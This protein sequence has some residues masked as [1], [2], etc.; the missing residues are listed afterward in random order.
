MESAIGFFVGGEGTA[1]A[2]YL[3][4]AFQVVLERLGEIIII[5]E[6][7]SGVVGGIDVDHLHPVGVALSEDLEDFEI[8]AFDVEVV[9]VVFVDTFVLCGNEGTGAGLAGKAAGFPFPRRC[10]KRET[11]SAS[12]TAS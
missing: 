5:D 10:S 2:I 1:F 3:A 4:G 7:V 12:P 9:G 6:V 8:V 11:S